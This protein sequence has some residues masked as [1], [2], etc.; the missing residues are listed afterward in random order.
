MTSNLMALS[1]QEAIASALDEAK[2]TPIAIGESVGHTNFAQ[3]GAK[4]GKLVA[5]EGDEA[6]VEHSSGEQ[7]RWKTEGMVDI[8]RVTT[9]AAKFAERLDTLGRL[10]EVMGMLGISPQ[11]SLQTLLGGG[12]EGPTPGCDCPHCSQ[13]TPEEHEAARLKLA[14]QAEEEVAEAVAARPPEPGEETPEAAPEANVASAT[15][16]GFP[17]DAFLNSMNGN[18]NNQ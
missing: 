14:A 10:V 9:L 5:Y 13:F 12:D 8:K 18:G 15:A 1:L 4:S 16:S 6:V 11:E 3:Y 2:K 17:F 7:I